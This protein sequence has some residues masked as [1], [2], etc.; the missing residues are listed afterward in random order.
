MLTSLERVKRVLS[1]NQSVD[2]IPI[3][4]PLQTG[5]L[6]LM[7]STGSYWPEAHRDPE[8]MTRLAMGIHT[9]VG[10]ENVRVPFDVNVESEAFGCELSWKYKDSQPSVKVPI[11]KDPADISAL[12]VPDPSR[13][14]RMPVVTESVRLLKERTEEYQIP[15]IGALIGPLMV[16]AQVRGVEEFM[17]EIIKAPDR[18]HELLEKA[19]DLAVEFGKELVENG[20]DVIAIVDATSSGS[21]LSPDQYREFSLPYAKRIVGEVGAP[22]VLHICGNAVRQLKLMEATGANCISLDSL[23]DVSVAKD[24]LSPETAVLGNPDVNGNLLWG[25]PEDVE[26]EVRTII[27]KGADILGTSCGIGPDTPTENL[28]ALV[29][30]GLRY[31]GR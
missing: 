23:V 21:L 19:T 13:D 30:A 7:E 14:G 16:A 10:F 25:E 24:I 20:A 9:I 4:A 12:Q 22:T 8:L 31:G 11:I 2:R 18:C 27:E 6:E 26:E 17:V 5:T 29:R 28:K 15:V 1:G 3:I